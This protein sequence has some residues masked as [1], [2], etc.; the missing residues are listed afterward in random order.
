MG[1][2]IK[3][4]LLVLFILFTIFLILPFFEKPDEEESGTRIKQLEVKK[5]R[6]TGYEKKKISWMV[7]VDYVWAGKS[8]F[9]FRAEKV[10][11]GKLYDSK[12]KVVVDSMRADNVKVNSK[13]KTLSAY[14]NVSAILKKRKKEELDS[15]DQDSEI[16]ISAN[17]LKFYSISKRTYLKHNIILKQKD[18]T[19][20]PE[21]QVEV[22][23]NSN[24]AYINDPFILTT[25]EMVVS[26]N[27]MKIN[28][29]KE[30]SEITG[31]VTG[32]RNAEIKP[33][34][35]LDAREQLLRSEK[36]LLTA[37][38]LFYS[39][40][41]NNTIVKAEGNLAVTQ[42]DKQLIAKKGYY[43]KDD[44]FYSVEGNIKFKAE[45]LYWLISEEKKADFKNEEM[46]QALQKPVT[47]SCSKIRFKA[48]EKRLVLV[49]DVNIKQDN[50]EIRCQRLEFSDSDGILKLLGGVTIIRKGHDTL[51]TRKLFVDIKAESFQAENAISVEWVPES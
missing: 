49:G 31:G 25:D 44:E 45:S 21:G 38:Y 13:S 26:A 17:E 11:E 51:E 30:Y 39:S 14:N 29:D 3:Q 47:I 28:I 16:K 20:V 34:S 23:N 8:K 33:D 10:N 6:I 1:K 27:K 41:K 32:V 40:I 5:S 9:L 12:G 22:D 35:D 37:D 48:K 2:R 50:Q 4:I 7:V 18:A 36:T 42:G 46:R 43:N 19:I 15:D 24:T